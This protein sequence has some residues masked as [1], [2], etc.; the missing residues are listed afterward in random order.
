MLGAATKSMQV[1]DGHIVNR[2]H[3]C[4]YGHSLVSK[5]RLFLHPWQGSTAGEG[6]AQKNGTVHGSR[7]SWQ[8]LPLGETSRGSDMRHYALCLWICT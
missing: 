6:L 8:L 5:E 4:Y 7:L 1:L 2:A 3:V